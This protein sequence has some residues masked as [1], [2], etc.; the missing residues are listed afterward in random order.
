MCGLFQYL[1]LNLIYNCET[2]KKSAACFAHVKIYLQ[3]KED[4]E[5][6][7]K[8]VKVLGEETTDDTWK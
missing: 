7:D 3:R 4:P 5:E 2:R 6:T 8:A 1:Y